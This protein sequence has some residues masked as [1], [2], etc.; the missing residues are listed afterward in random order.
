MGKATILEDFENGLYQVQIRYA[1][2]AENEAKIVA[3]NESISELQS[4]YDLMPDETP[5]E[6]WDKRIKG[7]QIKSLEKQVEY[8]TNIF[9]PD[10]VA[11]AHC[12]D[13]EKE[14]TGDVGLIEIPGELESVSK[15]NVVAG[16]AGGAAWNIERDGQLWPPVAM[17]PWST[18]LNKCMLPGWQKF[19]PLYRY[20]T[21][22][23]DSI[24][25]D[26]ST[27]DVCLDPEYSSQM[28]LPVNQQSGF[29]DCKTFDIP[30]WDT[31]CADN[32]AHET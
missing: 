26:N 17:G 31:F 25:F 12:I 20:G 27:C 30:Q 3:L 28:N 24:D 15:I 1:G 21:I 32:P 22:V 6:I 16:Y 7:L 10:P 14:L 8:L 4:E 13:G 2:R 29:Q 23:A 19:L 9:P 11:Y 5:D 18:F